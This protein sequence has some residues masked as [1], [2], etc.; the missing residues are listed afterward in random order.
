MRLVRSCQ[1][2]VWRLLE[3]A[4][5]VGAAFSFYHLLARVG[6]ERLKMGYAEGASRGALAV[7]P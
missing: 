4:S 3:A 7:R 1:E 2:R 6:S 5:Q